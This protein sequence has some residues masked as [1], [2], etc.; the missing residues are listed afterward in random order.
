MVCQ[1]LTTKNLR[2]RQFYPLRRSRL[3][4]TLQL[5]ATAISSKETIMKKLYVGNFSFS[6]TEADLRQ[7]FEPHG[8]VESATVVTDRDTGRSRGFGFVEMTNGSEAD[9]AILALNGSDVDGRPLTVNEARAKSERGG[10]G[11]GRGGRGGRGSY[12]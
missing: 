11:G 10:F 1:N 6:A 7:W 4:G 2:R 12:R 3:T 5:A 9:A 8:A